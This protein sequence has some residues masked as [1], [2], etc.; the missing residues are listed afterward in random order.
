MTYVISWELVNK[1]TIV[2]A[3]GALALAVSGLRK[4]GEIMRAQMRGNW[5]KSLMVVP[6]SAPTCERLKSRK[7]A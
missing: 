2:R 5:R 4:R 6:E 3:R 1:I 7:C